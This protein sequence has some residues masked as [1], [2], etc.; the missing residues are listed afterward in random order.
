[1][2]ALLFCLLLVPSLALAK[3]PAKRDV[4]QTIIRMPVEELSAL[5]DAEARVRE[6]QDAIARYTEEEKWA[7]LDFK[8]ARHWVD[9]GKLIIKA[10]TADADAAKAWARTEDQAELAAQLSRAESNQAWREARADE[11]KEFTSFQGARL[12]WAKAALK[13]D[14][15]DVEHQRM[16]AYDKKI[17]GSADSQVE[18][19]KL[20]QQVGRD[21]AAEGKARQKMEKAEHAWQS[22][23]DKATHLDPSADKAK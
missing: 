9:A 10:L 5:R 4:D 19:G 22:A 3:P 8:A 21:A 23:A 12:A 17:G 11:A 2:R 15:A 13:H 20:Q 6:D 7:Q 14:E 18:I 1:M 16:A